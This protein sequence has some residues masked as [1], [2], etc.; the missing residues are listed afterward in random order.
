MD[1]RAW[2]IYMALGF[3]FAGLVVVCIYIGN[4]FDARYELKGLGIA[5]GALFGL[6][7][8]IVHF[9]IITKSLERRK[10]AGDGPTES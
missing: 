2:A 8:W 1:R 3:E 10:S 6:V 4:W 9:I 7:S 5:G